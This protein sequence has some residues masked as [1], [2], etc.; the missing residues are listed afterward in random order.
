MKIDPSAP[1][2]DHFF[3]NYDVDVSA[4]ETNHTLCMEDIRV[5]TNAVALANALLFTFLH[6]I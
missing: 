6:C 3:Q 1:F 5:G 4:E 2:C